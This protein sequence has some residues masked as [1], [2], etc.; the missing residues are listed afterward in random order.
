LDKTKYLEGG[1]FTRI[2]PGVFGEEIEP[3]NCGANTLTSVSPLR[4][5]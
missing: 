2:Q 1:A 5:F 3:E 4:Y